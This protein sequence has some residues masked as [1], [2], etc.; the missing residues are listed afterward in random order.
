M[1]L[2]VQAADGLQ[3]TLVSAGR[4]GTAAMAAGAVRSLMFSLAVE[5]LILPQGHL[6]FTLTAL[7]FHRKMQSQV[8]LSET[9]RS[10]A[11]LLGFSQHH[12]HNEGF[13]ENSPPPQKKKKTCEH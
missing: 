13:T 3:R 1:F 7:S 9:E 11:V 8:V 5:R 10:A 2:R 6:T 4:E 12:N